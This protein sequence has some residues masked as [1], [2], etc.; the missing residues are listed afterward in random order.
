MKRLLCLVLLSLLA[1]QAQASFTASVDRARLSEGESIDLT[2]ESDDPTLFGK[3]DLSP[4]AQQFDVLGTRQVNHLTTLNGK[5]QAT[6]RWIVTLQPRQ[7]GLVI[8]PPLH[9]GNGETRPITL[10]VLKASEDDPAQSLSPVFIDASVD[11]E[12]PYVQAQVILTLRIYHSVSLYDDSSLS[13]LQINDARVESLGQARTYE[14][15]INGVRHGVIEVRYA[16]FP[17]RSGELLIPGQTFTATQVA[18]A[19]GNAMQPFGTRPGKQVR[20]ISPD[21]PLQVRAKPAAYPADLPWLPAR[22]VTISESWTPQ[23]EQARAGDSLTRNLMLRVEGLSS[24]QLPPLPNALPAGLR[25]Y[26]DQAQLTDQTTDQGVV[27]S[28]EEREA[29]VPDQAGE[30]KLPELEVTWWNIQ[31]DRLEHTSVPAR[32]LNVAPGA[33]SEAPP[34]A[35]SS[36]QPAAAPSNERLWPWQLATLLLA[37]T[38]LAGFALWWRAR[39]LPA[40]I[41]AAASGPSPR[42]LLD[43]LRRACQAND[44]QATRQAL[45]AWARQQPETLADMAARFVPLSDALDSLNGALYS[46]SEGGH[47]WNGENLWRAI[48]ALPGAQA[49]DNSTPEAS[50]LPPLY[51]R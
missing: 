33:Q 30:V 11:E 3:P 6:T 41:R 17:Q 10:H 7:T 8:V 29:L 47:T 38:T 51:P 26:P 40:V 37:L 1:F 5:A 13:P 42:T 9:L 24:A 50:G 15:E 31:E 28:R 4:L 45:D 20:V 2:L 22:A 35:P 46:D 21:I 49:T 27:G 18:R 25:H 48:Q 23:P 43:E 39:R 44:T 16:L 32:T 19:S 12:N 14:K 34:L 36:G